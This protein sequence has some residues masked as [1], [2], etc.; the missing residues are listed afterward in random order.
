MNENIVCTFMRREV[1][2]S[3]LHQQEEG[4]MTKIFHIKIQVKKTNID[5]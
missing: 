4:E 5:S 3:N 2:L 1:N